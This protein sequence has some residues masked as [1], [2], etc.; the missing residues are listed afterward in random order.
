[1]VE[2]P[3]NQMVRDNSGWKLMTSLLAVG[4]NTPKVQQML[5]RAGYK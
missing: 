1:M 4:Q 2:P 5:D 3:K